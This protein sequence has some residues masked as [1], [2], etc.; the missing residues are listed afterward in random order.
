MAPSDE[1]TEEVTVDGATFVMP[2]EN[3]DLVIGSLEERGYQI[4]GR[5]E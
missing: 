4:V 1:S 2:S 3:I 5:H